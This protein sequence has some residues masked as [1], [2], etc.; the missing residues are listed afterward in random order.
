MSALFALGACAESARLVETPAPGVQAQTRAQAQTQA[1]AQPRTQPQTQT[2][3][4]AQPSQPAPQPR[5]QV[6]DR[7]VDLRNP[8]REVTPAQQTAAASVAAQP[9]VPVPPTAQSAAT[10]DT[11]TAAERTAAT[12]TAPAGGERKLG[13]AIASLGDPAD[14]GLWAKTP[15]V[16]AKGEGRLEN[17]KTGKSVKVEL[18]PAGASGDLQVSLSA[19]R[20]LGVSLTDLPELA[21]YGR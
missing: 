20:A 10:L 12:T 15:L 1:Q 17:P 6:A 3:I 14:A 16:K 8:P 2:R 11:T 7:P 13:T 5:A 4:Q 21:V 18:R 9:R 19:Y